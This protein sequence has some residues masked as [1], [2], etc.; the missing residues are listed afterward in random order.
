MLTEHL[1]GVHTAAKIY[2][3]LVLPYHF[4]FAVDADELNLECLLPLCSQFVLCPSLCCRVLHANVLPVARLCS[5][6]RLR[7]H[8]LSN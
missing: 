6:K 1:F 2:T 8:V 4:D 7:Q 3:F 5:H